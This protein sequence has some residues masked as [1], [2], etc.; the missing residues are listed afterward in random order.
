MIQITSGDKDKEDQ[1]FLLS[2]ICKFWAAG[3]QDNQLDLLILP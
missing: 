3:K 1:D 2:H